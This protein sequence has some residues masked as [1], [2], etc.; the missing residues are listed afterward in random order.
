ML[1]KNKVPRDNSL[2]ARML[3]EMQE[4]EITRKV[5]GSKLPQDFENIVA[6]HLGISGWSLETEADGWFFVGVILPKPQAEA[7]TAPKTQS[8]STESAEPPAVDR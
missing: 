4:G 1:R 5:D 6:P 3:K 2:L 7:A 8:E